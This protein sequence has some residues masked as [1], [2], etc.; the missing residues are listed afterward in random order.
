MAKPTL[1]LGWGH[2]PRPSEAFRSTCCPH[3][4]PYS[5]C[6]PLPSLT[7]QR[8]TLVLRVCTKAAGLS[9]LQCDPLSPRGLPFEGE[10]VL[11]VFILVPI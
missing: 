11:S 7:G 6:P 1:G 8:V 9:F 3:P 10:N 4:P 5:A 2:N